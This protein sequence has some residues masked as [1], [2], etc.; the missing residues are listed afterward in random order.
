VEIVHPFHP[1]ARQQFQILKS[2]TV[3]GVE[4]LLLKGSESGTF[5]VPKDWTSLRPRS[6]YDDDGVAPR[7][8][9]WKLLVQLAELVNTIRNAG[10]GD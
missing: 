3:S 2:R 5:S 6:L 8:L 1:L 4:C 10:S 9:D 7:R